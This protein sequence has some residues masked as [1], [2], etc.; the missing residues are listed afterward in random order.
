MTREEADRYLAFMRDPS[1]RRKCSQCPA[2]EQA[3]PGPQ[4]NV[5]PCG[6]YHCWVDC[7]CGRV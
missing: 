3:Q 5:L 2:N 6:Q 1:N 7:H 4:A